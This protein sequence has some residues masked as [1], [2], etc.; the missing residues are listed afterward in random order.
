MHRL[1]ALVLLA[2][3]LQA[4]DSSEPET[5][6]TTPNA[7]FSGPTASV[8]FVFINVAG[9]VDVWA[10]GQCVLA[11]SVP[12]QATAY[13]PLPAGQTQ[14]TSTTTFP[15]T[16]VAATLSLTAGQKYTVVVMYGQRTVLLED[17][18]PPSGKAALRAV[19]GNGG[20]VSNTFQV[21]TA[22]PGGSPTVVAS[23]SLVFGTASPVVT[24][25][26]GNYVLRLRSENAGGGGVTFANEVAAVAGIIYTYISINAGSVFVLTTE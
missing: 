15:S 18:P 16:G 1:L 9:N 3:L 21:E 7:T 26:P 22:P 5:E 12:G 17:A 6:C 23:H 24:V 11:E 10:Q 25:N 20:Y 8:R 4:C 19:L 2:A 14:V 13:V